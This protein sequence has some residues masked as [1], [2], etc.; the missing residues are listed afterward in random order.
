MT[1]NLDSLPCPLV[2]MTYTAEWQ[3]HYNQEGYVN[4]DPIVRA[5]LGGVLPIDWSKIR[6]DDPLVLKFLGEAQEFKIGRVSSATIKVRTARQ[7]G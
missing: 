3:K 7:T 2:A 5:G 4:I 1:V 6:S